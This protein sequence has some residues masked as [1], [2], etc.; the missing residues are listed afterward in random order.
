MTALAYTLAAVLL[1]FGLAL[2]AG[3]IAALWFAV[4]S[5]RPELLEKRRD[6]R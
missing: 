6:K 4:S 3:M 1:V 5:S 2:G